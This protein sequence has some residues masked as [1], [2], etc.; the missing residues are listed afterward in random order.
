MVIDRACDVEPYARRIG[1][2]GSQVSKLYICFFK[3]LFSLCF[4]CVNFTLK[5]SSGLLTNFILKATLR[6][7]AY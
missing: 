4:R 6:K 2:E 5:T 3:K 1:K 7:D